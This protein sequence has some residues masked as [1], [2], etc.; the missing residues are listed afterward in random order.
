MKTYSFRDEWHVPAPPERVWELIEQPET[1]PLWWPI[2]LDA[3]ITED[4]GPVGSVACLKFRV[5]LPY[6]LTITTRST[7]SEAPR[8]LEGTVGGELEGTWRWTLEPASGGTRVV[9]EETVR[10]NRWIL[11][12]LGPIA[13]RLFAMNH[14]IAAR[15]GADGMRAYLA[16]REGGGVAAGS[17]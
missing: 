10:T 7:R 3:R 1:Y 5:L 15:K 12:L 6:T 11:D 8:L 16:R 4:N 14:A 13:G 17:T 9:F 2:Y